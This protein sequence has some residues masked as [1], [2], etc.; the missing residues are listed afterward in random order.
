MLM[1]KMVETAKETGIEGR[2]VNVSSAI[3][4]WFTGDVISYLAHICRNKR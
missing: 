2:I 1:K 4:G 3:H